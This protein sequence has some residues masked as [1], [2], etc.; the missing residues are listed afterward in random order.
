MVAV[1]LEHVS[2]RLRKVVLRTGYTTL[3]TPL[4]H[5]FTGES[6]PA[7]YVE[8]LRD[9][10]LDAAMLL[11]AGRVTAHGFPPDVVAAYRGSLAAKE[12]YAG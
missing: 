11:E 4:T 6:R 3:K 9:V 8:A 7:E 12:V 2:K 10:S 1:V 5:L